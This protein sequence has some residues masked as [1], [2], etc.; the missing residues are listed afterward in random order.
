LGRVLLFLWVCAM[1][2]AGGSTAAYAQKKTHSGKKAP[3][4]QKDTAVKQDTV[5][6]HRADDSR[7]P[8]QAQE[9][10]VMRT[11]ER[12]IVIDR[13]TGKPKVP[14]TNRVI[15]PID[16][17]IVLK[18]YKKKEAVKQE[19]EDAPA[20]KPGTTP[21][22]VRV[23]E[24]CGCVALSLKASDTLRPDDYVNYQFLFKNNC[25]ESVWISSSAFSFLVFLKN[26]TPAR[27]LRKL[28]YTRQ[29][30]Y[31]D[32]VELKPAEE[33][34]FMFGDDAFYQYDLHRGWEYKFTFAYYNNL[35]YR[36]APAKTYMC[37]QFR[38]KMIFIK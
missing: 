16:T 18:G 1:M 21:K 19:D 22:V 38:D 25:K 27:Q 3:A 17:V 32:F 15:R 28:N 31:P 10:A 34:T 12:V 13:A 24:N 2:V 20:G 9:G 6:V 4:V 8:P 5:I 30:N 37:S 7:R 36:G 26:G 11:V 23:N 14:D 35:K 33:F 29:Y